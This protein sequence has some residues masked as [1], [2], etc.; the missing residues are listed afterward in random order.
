MTFI[1]GDRQ[2]ELS[3]QGNRAMQQTFQRRRAM[4]TTFRDQVAAFLKARPGQWVDGLTL[5]SVGGVY[6][7]RTRISECRRQLGMTIRNRVR[8]K[9]NGVKV[10]EYC[11]IPAEK[12]K[13]MEIFA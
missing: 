1:A 4:S 8:R 7:S 5:A 11:Y 13:Q 6:A 9:P 12:P 3:Q 10:S 2:R